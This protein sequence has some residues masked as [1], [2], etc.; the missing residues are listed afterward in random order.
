MPSPVF[1]WRPERLRVPLPVFGSGR[2]FLLAGCCRRGFGPWT[3]WP[4]WAWRPSSGSTTASWP[5]PSPP[6]PTPWSCRSSAR[7]R[8]STPSPR[9]ERP[10]RPHRPGPVPRLADL[11]RLPPPGRPH[12]RR[13][14]RPVERLLGR[15][16][17]DPARP[18]APLAH[19]VELDPGTPCCDELADHRATAL[20]LLVGTPEPAVPIGKAVRE[21]PRLE[22]DPHRRPGRAAGVRLVGHAS[23]HGAGIP[24]LRYLPESLSPL[25]ARVETALRERLGEEPSFVAFEGYDTIAVSPRRCARTAWTG[26]A[27]PCPGRRRHRGNPRPRQ[28]S[29]PPGSG[30]WQWAWPPVQVVDRD[31]AAP[32]SI[33]VLYSA[34]RS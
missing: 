32:S 16:H 15:R 11:R 5:G 3:S 17:P 23:A 7:Q 24:F 2:H 30:V 13:R 1:G 6:G 21:D 4:N 9:A 12:P 20:L 18:P 29:C 19:V 22:R 28:F 34:P 10:R 33:R 25:G 14:R 27:S 8:C 31:P 26:R